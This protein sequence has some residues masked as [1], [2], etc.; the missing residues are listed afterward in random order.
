MCTYLCIHLCCAASR[1]TTT[2]GYA[3]EVK[4]VFFLLFTSLTVKCV[5]STIYSYER[6]NER[7]KF[8]ALKCV[9]VF[10]LHGLRF[11]SAY[12]DATLNCAIHDEFQYSLPLPYM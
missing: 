9:L 4:L 3:K 7:I 1:P 6:T 10:G 8:I 2:A 12:F 5:N 11:V